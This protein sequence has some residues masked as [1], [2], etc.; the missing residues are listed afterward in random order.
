MS[1]GLDYAGKKQRERRLERR[2]AQRA[3]VVL[4]EP[5]PYKAVAFTGVLGVVPASQ[6]QVEEKSDV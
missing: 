5:W 2:E 1:R 3:P 4:N 6:I